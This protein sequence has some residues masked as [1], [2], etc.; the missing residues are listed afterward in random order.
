MASAFEDD[1]G[2]NPILGQGFQ[3][4]ASFDRVVRHGSAPEP[5]RFVIAC[6]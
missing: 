4:K 2:E 3:D 6:K 5:M 1:A